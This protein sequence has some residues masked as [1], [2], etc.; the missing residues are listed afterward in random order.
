MGAG[1]PLVTGPN[2][3]LRGASPDRGRTSCTRT[4][5][6]SKPLRGNPSNLEDTY[7]LD[8]N[9]SPRSTGPAHCKEAV[10]NVGRRRRTAIALE[11]PQQLTLGNGEVGIIQNAVLVQLSQLA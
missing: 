10:L 6:S 4:D 2:V 7:V 5:F 1:H 9:R 8:D 3:T 11:L